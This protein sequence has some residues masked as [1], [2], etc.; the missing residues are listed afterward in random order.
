MFNVV[1]LYFILSY[2]YISCSGSVTSIRKG[3]ANVSAIVYC[4]YV[5]FPLSLGAWDGLRY[6]IVALP[7]I[8]FSNF[9]FD[10]LILFFFMV[11]FRKK[12]QTAS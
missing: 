8:Y 9:H 5:V 10:I 1:F 2:L 3:K 4:Y 6:F 12:D 11:A 7:S